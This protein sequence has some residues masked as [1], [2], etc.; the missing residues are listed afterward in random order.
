MKIVGNLMFLKKVCGEKIDRINS[1]RDISKNPKQ[2]RI[3]RDFWATQNLAFRYFGGKPQ[4]TKKDPNRPFYTIKL[5]SQFNV[6][7]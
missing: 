3:F 5:N 1:F 4:I 2:V 6:P 7:Y